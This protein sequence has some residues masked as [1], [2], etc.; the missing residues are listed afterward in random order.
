M[1]K[2][3]ICSRC[4]GINITRIAGQTWQQASGI[5]SERCMDC[6]YEGVIPEIES[7]DIPKFK[8]RLKK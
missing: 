5:F 1:S 3:K 7:A 2:V 8:K 4:G 6:G